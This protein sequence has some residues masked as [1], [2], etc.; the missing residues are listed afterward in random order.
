MVIDYDTYLKAKWLVVFN[1]IIVAGSIIALIAEPKLQFETKVGLVL[2]WFAVVILYNLGLVL[3]LE[4]STIG[5]EIPNRKHINSKCKYLKGEFVSAYWRGSNE[6]P[7]LV[8]KGVFTFR[9]GWRFDESNH[10]S[11]MEF[12]ARKRAETTANTDNEVQF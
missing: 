12:I 4:E 5:E 1:T 8:K 2:L 11:F 6:C 9:T 10:E 7:V 3:F